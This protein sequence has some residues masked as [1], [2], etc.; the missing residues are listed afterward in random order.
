MKVC[1]LVLLALPAFGAELD[2]F[3]DI[4]LNYTQRNQ[5]CL[6]L[7]GDASA[8]VTSH[9]LEGAPSQAWW[10][11]SLRTSASP[12]AFACATSW[13]WDGRRTRTRG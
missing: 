6:S 12:R 3:L 1:L 8:D 9:R 5:A 7:R 13:P 4:G 2:R 10:A 11:S